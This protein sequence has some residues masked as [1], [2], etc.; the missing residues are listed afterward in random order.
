MEKFVLKL[1][2]KEKYF[3]ENLRSKEVVRLAK[4]VENCHDYPFWD[5]AVATACK[6]SPA[7]GSP[8]GGDCSRD[9]TSLDALRFTTASVTA[10]TMY[11]YA[12][13]SDV[14]N[15]RPVADYK[16]YTKSIQLK[17]GN[18][19]VPVLYY[20]QRPLRWLLIG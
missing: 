14:R 19:I 1:E 10:S 12:S 18:L 13:T 11:C 4:V 17:T 8:G 16:L 20:R 2:R 9:A 3:Q 15:S 5:S 6:A 7:A